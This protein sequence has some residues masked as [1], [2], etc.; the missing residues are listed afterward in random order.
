MRANFVEDAVVLLV[1]DDEKATRF[2]AIYGEAEN[3]LEDSMLRVCLSFLDEIYP[4]S[5]VIK[6]I[7]CSTRICVEHELDV[8]D[9]VRELV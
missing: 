7:D 2:L 3:S 9:L 8:F 6:I 4:V 5:V 1:T